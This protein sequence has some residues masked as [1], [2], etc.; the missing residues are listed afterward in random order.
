[1]ID[2]L[3]DFL[4]GSGLVTLLLVTL[5][6]T[7][8]LGW[9]AWR[10][11]GNR[12]SEMVCA[13]ATAMLIATVLSVPYLAFGAITGADAAIWTGPLDRIASTCMLVILA[14]ALVS[15]HASQH[16]RLALVG[17]LGLAAVAWS[18]WA[19]TW[20]DLYRASPRRF[21]GG[22]PTGLAPIWDLALAAGAVALLV[23]LWKQ[24]ERPPSWM[25]AIIGIL[26]LGALLDAMAP[27]GATAAL[28]MRLGRLVSA[29]LL[30]AVAFS[31]PW[32]AEARGSTASVAARRLRA[33]AGVERAVP[34]ARPDQRPT[35]Y[36]VRIPASPSPAG[37]GAPAHLAK[38]ESET[39]AALRSRIRDL[40]RRVVQHAHSANDARM[41][42]RL[43]SASIE[44]LPLAM[45]VLDPVGRVLA[46]NPSAERRLRTRFEVG[47]SLPARLPA[48]AGDAIARC[49]REVRLHGR[50]EVGIEIEGATRSVELQA[51][52]DERG[53][54]A[55]SL[56]LVD[57]VAGVSERAG[58]LVPPIV[59]AV[60]GPIRSLMAFSSIVTSGHRISEAEIASR[61]ASLDTTLRRLDVLLG[62][63]CTALEIEQGA[64]PAERPG[65]TAD[66]ADV[67]RGCVERAQPL[68]AEKRVDL[69][70]AV[71]G[72]LPPAHV[73]TQVL[74][75]IVDNLLANAAACSPHGSRTTLRA[76]LD[77]SADARPNVRVRLDYRDRGR[78]AAAEVPDRSSDTAR[79]GLLIARILTERSRCLWSE[80][81]GDDGGTK[82]ELTIP[83]RVA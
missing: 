1:M 78:A 63:L 33:M 81:V 68:Y 15:R 83:T 22:D 67:L 4:T 46:H 53:A 55:G 31:A 47:T 79:P 5:S 65:T 58:E 74:A 9:T 43:C 25:A 49:L 60:R 12:A 28:W 10:G 73:D 19:M 56:L 82:V 21:A 3:I 80:G 18:S 38:A 36:G 42:A 50:A 69:A 2:S 40:D 41:A 39:I 29:L 23:V 26:A 66:V 59:E 30:A 64:S 16:L 32:H 44:R 54:H 51:L 61:I 72:W 70:L 20:A 8:A 71:D 62:D 7:L 45:A 17:I 14:L 57:P 24:T 77:R 34:A 6:T 75:Q 76:T 11:G 35:P 13:T 37:E 27:S 52:L 48:A